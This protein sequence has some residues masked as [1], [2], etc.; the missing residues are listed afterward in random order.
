[1]TP[2]L[3]VRS[4][5]DLKARELSMQTRRVGPFETSAIGFGCMGLSHGYGPETERKQAEESRSARRQP[6]S[7]G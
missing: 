4:L 7:G 1:M 3:L 5:A 6:G 2:A